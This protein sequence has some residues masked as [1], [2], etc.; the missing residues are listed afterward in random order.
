MCPALPMRMLLPMTTRTLLPAPTDAVAR[1]AD[2]RP[3]DERGRTA[4]R[5]R[6]VAARERVRPHAPGRSNKPDPADEHQPVERAM[7]TGRDGGC[8]VVTGLVAARL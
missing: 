4:V 5:G 3:S 2:A 8:R 7:W 6:C 1:S